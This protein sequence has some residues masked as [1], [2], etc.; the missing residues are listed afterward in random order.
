MKKTLKHMVILAFALMLA[1]TT[2]AAPKLKIGLNNPLKGLY[3]LDVL[4]NFARYSAEAL[5]TEFV[6]VNDE[7]KNEKAVANVENMIASGVDGIVFFGLNDAIFPVISKKCEKAKVPFVLY[8]HLPTPKTLAILRKN[9]YFAGAVGEN[10]YDAGFPIGQYARKIGLKK[11]LIVAGGKKGD[12]T[13]EA[14]VKGFTEGFA[15]NGGKV[16]DVGWGALTRSDAMKKAEDL[17]VAHPD[18]D[19][20]Y[21]SGGDVGVGTL[22]VLKKHANIKAKLFVTDL[23]PDVL[24]GL[25][26]KEIAAANGAHWINSGFA[27]ALLHNRLAGHALVGTKKQAPVINVPILVLPNT[28]ADL[29]EKWWLDNMPYTAKE[30]QMASYKYNKGITLKS[31]EKILSSYSI[32]ERIEKRVAEGKLTQDVLKTLE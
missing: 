13:H 11:A 32:K 26:K 27:L 22:E 7:V 12:T 31:F 1:S 19:A 24:T 9:P 29:Y 4:E 15:K 23:D 3:C 16:I 25:K 17:L 20:I 6:A 14:R 5:N 30:I 21:A 8:D 10:D 2:M 18:V 28:Q